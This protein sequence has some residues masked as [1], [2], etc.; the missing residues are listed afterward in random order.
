MKFGSLIHHLKAGLLAMKSQLELDALF[1]IKLI[2]LSSTGPSAL[3]VHASGKKHANAVAK[4]KNFLS[5]E[6]A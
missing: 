3:T 1:A 4:V 2:E 5:Q 6:Q